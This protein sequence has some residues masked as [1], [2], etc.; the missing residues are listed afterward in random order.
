MSELDGRVENHTER[1]KS[2]SI[3][4]DGLSRLGQG[5]VEVMQCREDAC[6]AGMGRAALRGDLDCRLVRLLGSDVLAD[7][8]G[9]A[10]LEIEQVAER[11][12]IELGRAWRL[13]T[14][15]PEA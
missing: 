2:G 3:Q 11:V 13:G 5:A 10:A 6:V 7:V 15:L 1:A 12:P 9:H 14:L 8:A 4:L